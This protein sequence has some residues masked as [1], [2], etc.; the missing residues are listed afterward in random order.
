MAGVSVS[1]KC[2][3]QS[4]GRSVI[5]HSDTMCRADEV[6][7][8]WLGWT[9]P[10]CISKNY[11][12]DTVYGIDFELCTRPSPCQDMCPT[13]HGDGNIKFAKLCNSPY[14]FDMFS[15]DSVC[16]LH[17]STYGEHY[18]NTNES[19]IHQISMLSARWFTVNK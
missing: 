16:S 12:N 9:L 14:V 2:R 13:I 18:K 11:Y 8:S 15:L 17:I 5:L 1:Y 4:G 3:I 7:G 19:Y 10:G 6:Q